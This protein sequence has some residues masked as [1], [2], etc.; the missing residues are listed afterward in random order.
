MAR[1]PRQLRE[2]ELL[3]EV[4]ALNEAAEG[5]K[6]TAEEA[7]AWNAANEELEQYRARR[8]RLEELAGDPRN[9]EREDTG[10]TVTSFRRDVPQH[11]EQSRSQ[12]LRALEA[13]QGALA[14]GADAKLE[15]V[16]GLGSGSHEP[17]GV[18]A[19]GGATAVVTTGST[20][21]MLVAEVFSLIETLGYRFRP[22][23]RIAANPTTWDAIYRLVATADATNP[24][25]MP[26]GRGGDLPG[27]PKVEASGWAGTPTTSGSTVVT[28]GDFE[29]GFRI[30]DR[31]GA[32][33]E[34]IP[35]LFGGSNRYP[36]GQRGAYVCGGRARSRPRAPRSCR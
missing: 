10:L 9:I 4:R 3:D 6:F 21:V 18:I 5:R 31:V 30:F 22:S 16:T 25:L 7:A 15:D 24:A 11:L 34:L 33:L 2:R 20:A 1:K 12:A 35:H 8:Q 13:H 14:P 23:A 17:Q 26:A 19:A 32:Q 28:Y 27:I 29:H 36:A